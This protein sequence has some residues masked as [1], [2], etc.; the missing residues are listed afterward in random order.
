MVR[1][2]SIRCP[3]QTKRLRLRERSLN[4]HKTS[5]GDFGGGELHRLSV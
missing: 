2:A 1:A 4:H 3:Y 5:P